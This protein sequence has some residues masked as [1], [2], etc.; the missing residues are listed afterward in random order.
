MNKVYSM[1]GTLK[2]AQVLTTGKFR[3]LYADT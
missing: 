2:S 3:L 1:H